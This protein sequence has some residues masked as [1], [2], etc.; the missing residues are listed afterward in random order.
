MSLKNIC[1]QVCTYSNNENIMLLCDDCNRGFHT[2]CIGLKN[3]PSGSWYCNKCVKTETIKIIYENPKEIYAYIRV[4]SKGQDD[5]KYGRAGM[6]TQNTS[7]LNYCSKNNIFIK[8]TIQ[9]IG[10]AYKKKT[11]KLEKLIDRMEKGIPILVYSFNR[12]S[13]NVNFCKEIIKKLEFKGSYIISS[14]ENYTSKDSRFINDVQNGEQ[15]SIN[16]SE[17]MK[18]AFIRIK[19]QG[20]YIGKKPFGY[21]LLRQN[22]VCKLKK[23]VLEYSIIS[24]IKKMDKMLIKGSTIIDNLKT[25][26]PRYVWN[27]NI[28]KDILSKEKYYEQFL[29]D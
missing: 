5:T 21:N 17:R 8:E 12:F 10:S 24:E 6:F 28:L 2:H 7:I 20:G 3:I 14:T 18:N 19:D 1:C 23:N 13:R 4:S 26:Y 15:E 27:T 9:E 25:K 29:I 11:P 16:N 22:G